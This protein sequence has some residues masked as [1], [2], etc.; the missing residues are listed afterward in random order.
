MLLLL[1]KNVDINHLYGYYGCIFQVVL[2]SNYENR[3]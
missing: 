2:A 1:A 3:I